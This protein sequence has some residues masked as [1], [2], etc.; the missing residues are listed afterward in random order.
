MFLVIE[1]IYYVSEVCGNELDRELLGGGT[2]L[3]SLTSTYCFGFTHNNKFTVLN[4][5]VFGC[6]SQRAALLLLVS[7]CINASYIIFSG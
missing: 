4:W 6:D 1:V 3:S 5:T 7:K 2:L